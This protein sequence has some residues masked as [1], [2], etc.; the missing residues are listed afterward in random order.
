M[1]EQQKKEKKK[2]LKT[3][4]LVRRVKPGGVALTRH[5]SFPCLP[6]SPCADSTL[7]SCWPVGYV[8]EAAE[9]RRRACASERRREE[10]KGGAVSLLSFPNRKVP[11]PMPPNAGDVEH[12]EDNKKKTETPEKAWHP[13]N[14][15]VHSPRTRK[16][17]KYRY[18]EKTE[19]GTPRTHTGVPAVRPMCASALWKTKHTRAR[20]RYGKRRRKRKTIAG[21]VK[22]PVQVG[23]DFAAPGPHRR[24]PLKEED[25]EKYANKRAPTAH[26]RTHTHTQTHRHIDAQTL[27]TATRSSGVSSA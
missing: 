15:Q 27:Q 18:Q 21:R 6:P 24:S 2:E 9:E 11:W 13:A 1:L 26:P 14:V 23:L 22:V 4:H 8:K 25:K 10:D 17:A 20:L 19:T 3:R 12:A 7:T 16:A 5:L